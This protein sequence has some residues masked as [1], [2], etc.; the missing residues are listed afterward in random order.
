MLSLSTTPEQ[1]KRWKINSIFS[2]SFNTDKFFPSSF[3][4]I[5]ID[6]KPKL[7]WMLK[8]CE[9]L[10]RNFSSLSTDRRNSAL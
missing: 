6:L 7:Q 3:I 9:E 8:S 4:L 2:I 10:V 1:L 5:S